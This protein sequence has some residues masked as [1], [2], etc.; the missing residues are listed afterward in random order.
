M[1]V[2]VSG[3]TSL[4]ER[5]DPEDAKAIAHEI[6]QRMGTEVHRYGGTV[7]SVMG[8]AIMAVFGAPVAHEDDAE[9]AVRAGIAMRDSIRSVGEHLSSVQLHIGI[10]TGEGMAGLVGPEGR[11][12]YTVVGDVTNTAARLQSAAAAGE[13]LVGAET[14]TATAHIAEY[15]DHAAL[16]AKGKEDPLAVWGVIGIRETVPERAGAG[17]PLVGR[18]GELEL[19]GSIWDRTVKACQTQVVTV[20]GAPG[21]GKS[22][23]IREAAMPI[24]RAGRFIKGRCFPYGETTGYDAFGQQVKQ[25]AG[26]LESDSESVARDSLNRHVHALVP[27]EDVDEVAAHLS[28]L[29]GFATERSADKQLLFFSVRRYVRALAQERPTALVFEDLHWAEPTL[30]DLIQSLAARIRDAPLLLL[31]SARPEFFDA[32]PTWGSG[33]RYSAVPLEPLSELGSRQLAQS[34]MGSGRHSEEAVQDLVATSGGNPLFLEELTS[35]IAERATRPEGGLPTTI[36]AIIAARLDTLP[37][38]ERS[39]LQNASVVGRSFWRGALAAIG[40]NGAVLDATLDSLEL[41]D[42]IVRQP[43][44]RLARDPEYMFKHILTMEVAYGTLPRRSRRELHATVARHLETAMGDRIRESASLLAHHWK[45]ASEPAQAAPYLVVAAEVAARAAA[46]TE[47]IALFT[48]AIDLAD[49]I[50]DQDLRER[51]LFGRLRARIDIGESAAALMDVELLLAHPDLAVRAQ[52]AHARSRLGFL[53]GNAADVRTFAD[54]AR[55]IAVEIGDTRLET[56]AGAMAGAAAWLAG[57]RDTF[58]EA[59][60]RA[61]ETWAPEQRD[62]EYAFINSF[63]PLARYWDGR[64]EEGARLAREGFELGTELSSVYEM[65]FNAGNVGLN[66]IGSARYEE[67]F[68]WLER[69]TAMGRDWEAK[70]QWTGRTLNMHAGALREIG[71][72]ATAR[73]L[74]QEGLEAGIEAAFLAASVSAKI[75]LAMTDLMEGE[76]GQAELQMPELLEAVEDFHGWHQWLWAGRLTDMQAVIALGS[77]RFEEAASKADEALRYIRRYPRPKYEARAYTTH[78]QAMLALGLPNEA[79]TSFR[80]AVEGADG[81]RQPVLQWPA[82]D[83]LA[84]SLE[85]SGQ[86]EEAEGARR[87]AREVIEGVAAGLAPERRSLFLKSPTVLSV[88]QARQ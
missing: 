44:S 49:Q 53:L 55:Q 82:L 1:F 17:A 42:L 32:A 69:G 37:R 21:I 40:G 35:S 39:V 76:I 70:P 43:T 78:G 54:Q 58:L 30:L 4:V 51:A 47:A 45:G 26:I 41:R 66:L 86:E 85:R 48:E 7:I 61:A 46:K 34:L 12:D 87:R 56:R 72:L 83:G 88:L 75:D 36:Q 50:G 15:S 64:Y 60:A 73:R 79:S 81:L 80:L 57:D 14:H 59:R 84:T 6:T 3:W 28:I 22:R 62:A 31:T 38:H 52:A 23:L 8:D 19:L 33:L 74:S 18:E 68:E 71:D 20:S 16:V 9:R 24:E 11:S 77:G 2:D 25:T 63:V 65:I 27:P 5:L 13:I 10:N 67:A 29:L